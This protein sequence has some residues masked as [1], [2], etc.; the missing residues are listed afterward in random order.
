MAALLVLA[1]LVVESAVAGMLMIS[2]ELRRNVG[3][4]HMRRI[5]QYRKAFYM[6]RLDTK[7]ELA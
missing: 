2:L 7:P 6:L 3:R 5:R 4:P 1:R